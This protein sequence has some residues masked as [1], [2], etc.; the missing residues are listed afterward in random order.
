MP[1][2]AKLVEVARRVADEVL[3][4]AAGELDR[5]GTLPPGRLDRLAAEGL[6]G[7]VAP[8]ALGGAELDQPEFALVA[9]ELAGGCLATAFVWLQHHGLVRALATPDAPAAV[10]DEWLPGLATGSVRAGAA[11]GGTLPGPPR[12]RAD[13]A[14]FGSWIV[15][16]ESPWATGWGHVDVLHVAARGP[17]DTLVWLIVDAVERPGLRAHR[18]RTAAAD[19]ASTVRLEFAGL[20]VRASRV[21]AVVPYTPPPPNGPA[22]RGNGSLALGVAGRCTALMG[23]TAAAAELGAERDACRQAL[24]DAALAADPT[25]MPAARAAASELAVRS[26]A[27]LAVS[28]GSSAA[29]AGSPADRLT[30]EALFLLVFGSRPQIKAAL[31]DRLSGL[32]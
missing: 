20:P 6:Y 17:D 32:A 12:L 25:A 7:A 19:A 24:D 5:S 2:V 26:A 16:G 11:Y 10:R 29:L 3:F 15:S 13:P 21:T 23:P 9:E 14:P 31:L 1:D 27:A 18:L 30:R 4:P 22:L 28:T 8:V